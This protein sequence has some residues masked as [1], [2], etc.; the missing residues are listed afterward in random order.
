MFENMLGDMIGHVKIRDK[1]TNETIV[2]K[3]NKIHFGNMSWAVAG[4]LS[5]KPEGSIAYMLFG[6][7]GSTVDGSGKI[8]Y[9][10]PNVSTLQDPNALPYNTTFYKALSTFVDGVSTTDYIRVIDGTENFADLQI[11]VS[12]GFNEPVGQPADDTTQNISNDF[13]FDEIALFTQTTTP[14]GA[15]VD[16][17]TL[18]GQLPGGGRMVTHV[19]FHPQQK[20]ANRELEIEYTIRVQMGP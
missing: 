14:L 19:V 13:V 9:R 3:Y 11:V 10:A 16:P 2:D 6:N 18:Q 1:S 17:Q 20:A 4:A 5:G 8:L 7:G 12:L 15:Y